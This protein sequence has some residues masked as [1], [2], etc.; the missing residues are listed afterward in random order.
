MIFRC[1]HYLCRQYYSNGKIYL[2]I[3]AHAIMHLNVE[4]HGDIA[5]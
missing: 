2:Y 5:I 4:N 1:R 3:D